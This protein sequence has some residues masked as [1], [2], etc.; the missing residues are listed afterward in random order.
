MLTARATTSPRMASHHGVELLRE[1]EVGEL[2]TTSTLPMG[3]RGALS[4]L[5]AHHSRAMVSVCAVA[6]T[7]SAASASAIKARAASSV[8]ATPL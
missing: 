5:R 6:G 2:R 4:C 3:L 1:G 7:R 8:A